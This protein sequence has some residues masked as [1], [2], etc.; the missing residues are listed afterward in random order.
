MEK[1]ISNADEQNNLTYSKIKAYYNLYWYN[2][3]VSFKISF[4]GDNGV[5]YTLPNILSYNSNQ[6]KV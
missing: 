2:L 1:I 6:Q 5:C 3:N 4:A